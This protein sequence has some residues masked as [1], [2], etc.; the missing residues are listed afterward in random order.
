M[1]FKNKTFVCLSLWILFFVSFTQ[2]AK[3][4]DFSGLGTVTLSNST[5]NPTLPTSAGVGYGLGGTV[6]FDLMPFLSFETGAFFLKRSFSRV[7][8]ALSRAIDSNWVDLPALLRFSPISF[9]SL[10]G[11]LYYGVLTSNAYSP[12][13]AAPNTESSSNDFGLMVGAGVRLPVSPLIRLRLDF[14]YQYGL[15]NLN[16]GA[17]TQ[18]SRNIDLLAGLMFDVW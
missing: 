9:I 15:V 18:Y 12:P 11:G 3:A 16:S 7:D 17:S 1:I 14:F 10:S 5:F 4:L 6:G 2:E 13:L 8:P